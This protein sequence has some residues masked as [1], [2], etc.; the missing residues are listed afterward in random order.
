M[1]LDD[2]HEHAPEIA[3]RQLHLQFMDDRQSVNARVQRERHEPPLKGI[4]PRRKGGPLKPG[5]I[6]TLHDGKQAT[7]AYA[8]TSG[9]S[10]DIN[11]EHA[12][13]GV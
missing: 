8:S 1:L 9:E 5:N 6:V 13:K 2:I 4:P 10:D 3:I 12:T 11:G 7:P